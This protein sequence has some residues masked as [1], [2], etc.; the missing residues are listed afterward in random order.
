MDPKLLPASCLSIEITS[1]KSL[2]R[3]TRSRIACPGEY[4]P[5]HQLQVSPVGPDPQRRIQ[6]IDHRD[7]ANRVGQVCP[8]PPSC[9]DTDKL[10]SS[11]RMA[12]AKVH[13][14]HNNPGMAILLA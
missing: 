9:D 8:R 6:F 11:R 5:C 2:N 7:P 4:N 13:P 14:L 12:S 3:Y 10:A 1:N